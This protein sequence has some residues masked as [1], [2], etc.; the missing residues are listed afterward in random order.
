M[1]NRI[2]VAL[3]SLFLL[4]LAASA[5][6]G[7]PLIVFDPVTETP[8]AWPGPVSMYTDLDV[9]FSNTGPV[10]NAEADALC[11]NAMAAWSGVAS[12]TLSASVVGDFASVGIPETNLGNVFDVID[13]FNGGGYHVVYDSDGSII[14]ALAGPGVLGFSS[15]EWADTGTPNL[16]ESY[17]VLNGSTVDIGDVGGIWYQG[18]FT[19]EFGH[20]LNLA[21]TQTNGAIGFFGD[22]RGP[23]G[24]PPIAGS[25]FVDDLETMYPYLDPG[26]GGTGIAQGTVEHTD[27]VSALSDI[28][29]AAGWPASHASISGVI[30]DSDGV[31]PVTGVNVVARNL[32]D[33]F[34]DSNSMLSGANTQGLAGADGR[35]VLNGL[36]PG[37]DYVVYVEG[38]IAGGF[39]TTPASPFPG[40]EEY[41]NGANESSDA[42]TDLPCDFTTV[43][44]AAG[45]VA[46]ADIVF[47]FA[48]TL[49][50]DDS[51]EIP[52]PFTFAFCGG[53]FNSVWVGSNGFL[54]FGQP[55]FDFSQS[56]PELIGGPVRIAALWD[57]L[58]PTGGGTVI[59]E[60][61][62][63]SFRISY[64]GI[65]EYP[66]DG[67][68]TF[69]VTLDADGS[70]S[71]DYGDCSSLS[72]IVG[73]SPGLGLALD[74]GEIDIS[75]AAQPIV[76][77]ERDA[78]YEEFIGDFDLA[79]GFY[80]W[81][82]CPD[83]EIIIANA[84]DGV[85]YA[86][87]GGGD[88]GQL[89]SIDLDTGVGTLI[90]N[91]GP[92]D[93]IPGL[94]I[95][96]A[97]EIYGTDRISG[98]IYRLDA[99]DGTAYFVSSPGISFL[100]GIAFD[101]NDVLYAVGY[102]PPAFTLWTID[103]NTGDA[104]PVGPTGDIMVGLAFDPTD[105]Q[106]YGSVGGFLPNVADGIY[107][108]DKNTGAATL[109]G[110]TGI[111]GATPDIVFDEDGSLFGS[112]GGGDT[113]LISI[114]K[115]TGAGTVVG[116]FG[117]SS[118]S[119]LACY[120]E[121]F[122]LADLDIRP[123]FCPNWFRLEM[124]LDIDHGWFDW[125]EPRITVRLVGT[126]ELDVEEIDLETVTL[127]GVSASYVRRARD[128][129]SPD[130][131][132]GC[133]CH[134]DGDDDWK[135]V[136]QCKFN[137][138]DFD[139]GKVD[140]SQLDECKHWFQFP[141]RDGIKDRDFRFKQQELA[142]AITPGDPGD[143]LELTMVG[144]LEDGTKFKASDCIL[145]IGRPLPDDGDD[146]GDDEVAPMPEYTDNVLG[147]PVP[148]PFNPATEI[149]Y[150][151]ASRGRVEL[152]IYDIRGR[153][154]ERLVDETQGAGKHAVTWRAEN[155][156]SG[157]YYAR[158]STPGFSGTQK[159]ILV[160]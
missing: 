83:F 137:E 37:A 144:R 109:V 32:A 160:K 147:H 87:T 78:V 52:L 46:T 60:D 155:I 154:V 99:N 16:T 35:Y 103:V 85:C 49:G 10:T 113:S 141:D 145:F 94:A 64:V 107:R 138:N 8:Y 18:L 129:S 104:A 130:F 105:G 2:Q 77:A 108:I 20:G 17:A 98:D 63:G 67:S 90:G 69:S 121:P 126:E 54:T 56:V 143:R 4:S 86:S 119:G 50:D 14:A 112:K 51:Q 150:S 48:I 25:L 92:M 133:E 3:V 136:P 120:R 13:T 96:S 122:I 152:S 24:C 146:D 27:D 114:D 57:D 81:D 76:G 102:D 91:A 139:D 38:I 106:L 148:N 110:T 100:D 153:L 101:E 12:A 89:Y 65:P 39:S 116:N 135:D 111:G 33:P 72:S 151:I 47:N 79:N 1:K 73:H 28:Y 15:P 11:A 158:L 59:A 42:T 82:M 134:L 74:P 45:G 9:N 75:A 5:L 88:G 117:A 66:A 115:S 124:F 157:I 123:Y 80:D 93:G 31:T 97:G 132:D 22:E 19:H 40:P 62:G 34:A 125:F 71:V 7:G 30:Y 43:S 6:A 140:V 127:Q 159:L 118:L 26:I 68:N 23:A 53:E 149:S 142:A 36:T 21:H 29:P 131:N 84:T 70:Y 44:A 55:D 58:N 41:Y 128:R 61:L 95:N 156:A